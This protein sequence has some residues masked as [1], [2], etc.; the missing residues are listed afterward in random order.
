MISKD[1]DPPTLIFYY[2]LSQAKF[3]TPIQDQ[4]SSINYSVMQANIPR[5]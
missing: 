2:L 3:N 5:I 4:A 1:S